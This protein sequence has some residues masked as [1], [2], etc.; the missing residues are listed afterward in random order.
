MSILRRT[1]FI[2]KDNSRP[3]E[4]TY[5]RI[6]DFALVSTTLGTMM[7]PFRPFAKNAN[8]TNIANYDPTDEM[9]RIDDIQFINLDKHMTLL[10]GGGESIHGGLTLRTGR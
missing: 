9:S 3:L 5:H 10:S 2:E 8:G 1:I 4:G 7:E 6:C